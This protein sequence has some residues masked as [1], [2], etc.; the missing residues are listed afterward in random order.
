MHIVKKLDKGTKY[1]H[2]YN[3]KAEKSLN[4]TWNKIKT[5]RLIEIFY[6]HLRK[7]IVIFNHL[8]VKNK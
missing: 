1:E 5:K 2:I 3:Y 6:T 8:K 7:H 4:K